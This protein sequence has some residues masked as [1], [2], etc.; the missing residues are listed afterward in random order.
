ML[1]TGFEI[2]ERP[3]ETF[4]L[5]RSSEQVYNLYIGYERGRF[6]S[7]LSSNWRSEFLEEIGKNEDFDIY[8][9]DHNQLDLTLAFRIRPG[10]EIVAEVANIT[11]EPLELYQGSK[12]NNFQYEKYGTTF[13]LGVKGSF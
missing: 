1:D 5:P 11:D 7:R 13:N 3:G 12:G 8:V 2:D 10:I 9:A 4:Q 6:S